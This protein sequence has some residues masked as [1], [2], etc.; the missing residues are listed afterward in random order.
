M[1]KGVPFL[2]VEELSLPLRRWALRQRDC[3][4]LLNC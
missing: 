3:K 4:Q 2:V 1:P